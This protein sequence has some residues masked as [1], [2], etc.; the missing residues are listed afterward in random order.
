[1]AKF[2][3]I[4]CLGANNFFLGPNQIQNGQVLANRANDFFLVAKPFENG[5]NRAFWP[6]GGPIGNPAET[7]TAL[8]DPGDFLSDRGDRFPAKF[9]LFLCFNLVPVL[10]A[11]VSNAVSVALHLDSRRIFFPSGRGGERS[12]TEEVR[13]L[14]I[15]HPSKHSSAFC[16]LPVP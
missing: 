1:M 14:E 12:R 5:Q 9:F 7:T 13:D 11:S 6:P 16:S 3:P 4:F 15:S 10:S 8:L 2:G